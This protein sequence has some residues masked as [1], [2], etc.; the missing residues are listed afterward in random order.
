MCLSQPSTV[1]VPQGDVWKILEVGPDGASSPFNYFAWRPG[2]NASS[3]MT[4]ELYEEERRRG[5]VC[6][7]FHVLTDLRQAMEAAL[8]SDLFLDTSQ[9][10]RLFRM[11]GR[12]EDSVATGLW[13]QFDTT[14][15][16]AVY[17]KLENL[18][19]YTG[20]D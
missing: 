18:G 13:H 6:H 3:R 15:V 1:A 17:T 12:P 9:P 7:G 11:R 4:P 5:V 20:N 10:L 8:R 2:V 16:T 19:P 14:S